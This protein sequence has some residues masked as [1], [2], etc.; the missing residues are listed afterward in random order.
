[1][2]VLAFILQLP[3][4]VYTVMSESPRYY[5]PY[6]CILYYD[7]I[8]ESLLP[9]KFVN[10]L[11][12]QASWFK[13]YC[14]WVVFGMSHFAAGMLLRF[15]SVSP[16]KCWYSAWRLALI[17]SFHVIFSSLIHCHMI[18]RCCAVHVTDSII[19]LPVNCSYNN[20]TNILNIGIYIAVERWKYLYYFRCVQTIERHNFIDCLEL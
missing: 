2:A 10:A 7:A 11:E 5:F 16:C 1:M 14:F 19:K 3:I 20:I 12:V 4:V 8:S 6:E 17:T 18:I 13:Q 15:S 9:C